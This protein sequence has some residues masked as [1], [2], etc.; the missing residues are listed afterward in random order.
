MLRAKKYERAVWP[1]LKKLF[2]LIELDG[3]HKPHSRKLHLI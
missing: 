2:I 3:L 1:C